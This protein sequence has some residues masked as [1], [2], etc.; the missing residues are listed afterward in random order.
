[1]KRLIALPALLV[2]LLAGCTEQDSD[3]A[4]AQADIAE[5]SQMQALEQA[6][7]AG[8]L[9]D[10]AEEPALLTA[11]EAAN[12]LTKALDTDAYTVQ[13]TDIQLEVGGSEDGAHAF[14]VFDVQTASGSVVGQAAVDQQTGET[15]RYLGEGTLEALESLCQTDAGETCDWEGAYESP[16]LVGLEILQA[17]PHSFE[18]RFSDG[19]AGNADITGS[20]AKSQDG[21]MNFLYSD[22]IVT[23]V[24]GGMTGNY[25]RKI[26]V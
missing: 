6:K 10:E 9:T 4:A 26:A 3:A 20:T 12:L 11:Q 19:T 16:I 25:S 5:N 14:F 21:E 8:L 22:D 13:L 15:Y 18:Y 1:M 7:E 23:V 24:G 2:L 17:D